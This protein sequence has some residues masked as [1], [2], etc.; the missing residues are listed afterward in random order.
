MIS[1]ILQPNGVHTAEF[2]VLLDTLQPHSKTI[3]K[4]VEAW[5]E[6]KGLDC[7]DITILWQ[8]LPM[9]LFLM[10]HDSH[11]LDCVEK[12]ELGALKD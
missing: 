9:L 2:E 8:R 1:K 5:C 7:R 6:N 10:E 4:I 12:A 3:V 11:W